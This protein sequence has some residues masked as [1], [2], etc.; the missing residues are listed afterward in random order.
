MLLRIRGYHRV[1]FL[2]EGLYEWLARVMEPRLPLDA[3]ARERA[4]FDRAVEMSRFFGGT[5]REGVP[6]A[7]VPIGYWNDGTSHED[8][9]PG[10]DGRARQPATGR[11]IAGIRRRGC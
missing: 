2:R 8:P 5:A 1:F 4:D 3:T 6:R 9:N 11:M 7:D 10:A